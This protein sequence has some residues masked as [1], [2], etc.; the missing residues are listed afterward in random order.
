MIL[1]PFGIRTP[2]PGAKVESQ[3]NIHINPGETHVVYKTDPPASG[4]HFPT[5]PQR[6]TYTTP[7]VTEFLPHFLEHGGVEVQYNS[8]AP[9]D[10]VKKLTDIATQELD[11][12]NRRVLLAPR[13]D[14]PCQVALTSWGR[15][16]TFGSPGCQPG[17][18]GRD[19]SA[20][21]SKDASIVRDFIERNECQYDPEGQCGGGTK[22]KSDNRTPASGEPTVT[23]SLSTGSPTPGPSPAAASP[24]PGSASPTPAAGSP[25]P[26]AGSPTAT[27]AR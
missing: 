4:P 1:D 9:A 17:S 20:A 16:E 14:M 21:S 10:V 2:L 22:G 18:L 13:P 3:G 26:A 19:F 24:T 11:N 12:N 23:A 25:T 8:A 5:V 7:F 15:M 6:G 27:P